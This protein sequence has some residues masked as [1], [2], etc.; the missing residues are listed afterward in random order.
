MIIKL[1]NVTGVKNEVNVA[2]CIECY[3]KTIV[4]INIPL[5]DMT[6]V[7]PFE[8]GEAGLSCEICRCDLSNNLDPSV[9]SMEIIKHIEV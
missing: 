8:A 9:L 6:F 7:S 2:Y 1:S 4:L 3:K 5:E